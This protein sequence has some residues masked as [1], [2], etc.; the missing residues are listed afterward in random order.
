MK[1]LIIEDELRSARELEKMIIAIDPA[2][3]VIGTLES[4]EETLAWFAVN[5]QP[6]LIFSDIQLADGLSFE[7]Y[8]KIRITCPIIF[9]SAFDEY[10]MHAFE[11]N[12]ISYLLKPVT[13][14][15]VAAAL[16]KLKTLKAGFEQEP[17]AGDSAVQNLIKHLHQ[18]Y[19]NT[20]L[21]N[22]RE[23]IIPVLVRDI[24]YFYMEHTVVEAGTTQN[25]K[26][27]M[28][29]SLDELEKMVDPQQFY[30]ANRQFLINRA[31]IANAERFFSRKLVVR[32][33]VPTNESI[34]V[35]KAKA[36]EFLHWLQYN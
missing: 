30:R 28:T 14:E 19:K 3:Q 17:G 29:G 12:A 13:R 18:P 27:F 23:K 20:I 6:D 36:S 15:K 11:T 33:T 35:S 2:M 10:L 4:V 25:Q 34:V 21:V 5:A 8:E 9:C 1:V 22:L 32:L 31:A 7:I 16:N 24:A 26:Y